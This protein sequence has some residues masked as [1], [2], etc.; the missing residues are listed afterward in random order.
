MTGFLPYI[1]TASLLGRYFITFVTASAAACFVLAAANRGAAYAAA[2]A[3]IIAFN[4]ICGSVLYFLP[5]GASGG[6][7]GGG[8]S[9]GGESGGSSGGES[10]G[11]VV[12]DPE[13]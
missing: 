7:T 2:G 11:E 9:T 13:A 5:T 1:A 3:A 6:E 4:L 12:E 10:G 8:E